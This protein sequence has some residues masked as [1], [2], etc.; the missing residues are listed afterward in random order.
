MMFSSLQWM[1]LDC[2][3]ENHGVPHY[4]V[5][6]K[7]VQAWIHSL[8]WDHFFVAQILKA[9]SFQCLIF[10]LL[11]SGAISDFSV[12]HLFWVIWPFHFFWLTSCSIGLFQLSDIYINLHFHLFSLFISAHTFYVKWQ[13]ICSTIGCWNPSCIDYAGVTICKQRVLQ[14]KDCAIDRLAQRRQP[15]NYSHPTHPSCRKG[16]AGDDYDRVQKM[17]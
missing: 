9:T 14:G 11:I 13:H 1:D 12:F 6:E 2:S 15:S 4:T 10:C 7:I 5:C 16:V 3:Q 17:P 8:I